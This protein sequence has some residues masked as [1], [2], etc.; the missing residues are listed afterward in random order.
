MERLKESFD[1]MRLQR[2]GLI[3]A[4]NPLR[5]KWMLGVNLSEI[6]NC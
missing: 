2:Q 1:H 6:L 4:L 5:V 3:V